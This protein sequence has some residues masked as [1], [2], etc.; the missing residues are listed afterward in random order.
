MN[1]T[2][3]AAI[4]AATIAAT[5]PAAAQP[6]ANPS[7]WGI[8]SWAKSWV[9]NRFQQTSRNGNVV[10]SNPYASGVSALDRQYLNGQISWDYYQSQLAKQGRAGRQWQAEAEANH[11]MVMDRPGSNITFRGKR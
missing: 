10:K 11:N 4:L 6:I 3:I 2:T 5:T 7:G 1:R 8:A 9:N